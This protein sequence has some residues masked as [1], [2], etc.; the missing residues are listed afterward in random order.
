MRKQATPLTSVVPRSPS[1][2]TGKSGEVSPPS[3]STTVGRTFRQCPPFCSSN[4]FCITSHHIMFSSPCHQ[5]QPSFV[6]ASCRFH[7]APHFPI[8][9]VFLDGRSLSSH[10][11]VV[12]LPVLPVSLLPLLVVLLELSYWGGQSVCIIFPSGGIVYEIEITFHRIV[13]S[14]NQLQYSALRL[15]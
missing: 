8:T 4:Q 1:V 3:E 5:L 13:C 11:V 7:C 6:F 9:F 15:H 10:S 2:A 12:F 14:C